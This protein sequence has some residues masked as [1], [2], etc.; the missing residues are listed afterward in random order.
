MGLFSTAVV[1]E[2]DSTTDMDSTG[3]CA[4]LVVSPSGDSITGACGTD[5]AD[6][7]FAVAATGSVGE[8]TTCDAGTSVAGAL[9]TDAL[10]TD[11]LL[12]DALLTDALLTD[13]LPTGA[14]ATSTTVGEVAATESAADGATV[15]TLGSVDPAWATSSES[16]SPNQVIA[17]ATN[18]TA[19]AIPSGMAAR[20]ILNRRH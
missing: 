19:T 8:S 10:L 9:L 12:T 13:A 2:A 7:T 20:L 11:A 6:A 18:K 14:S 17:F 16:G 15:A 3:A 1:A 4:A 5:G